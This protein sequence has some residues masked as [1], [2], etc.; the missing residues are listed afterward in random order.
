MATRKATESP[1]VETARKATE[2]NP[3]K[4]AA[5]KAAAKTAEPKA[6]PPVYD[7]RGNVRPRGTKGAKP[8]TKAQREAIAATLR[9]EVEDPAPFNPTAPVPPAWE[10]LD[11]LPVLVD[12]V[13]TP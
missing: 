12:D 8:M 4:V 3:A 9:A 13:A 2:A 7:E 1:E 10:N 11:H 6:D 5:R